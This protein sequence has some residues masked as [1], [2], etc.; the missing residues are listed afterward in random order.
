MDRLAVTVGL[1]LF[2]LEL[3][4]IREFENLPAVDRTGLVD[5]NLGLGFDIDS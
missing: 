3:K 4:S 1:Q 2:N 5:D